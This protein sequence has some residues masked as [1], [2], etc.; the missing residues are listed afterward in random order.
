MQN[1]AKTNPASEGMSEMD[2]AWMVCGAGVGG[3]ELMEA[4]VRREGAARL[5]R[6]E[7]LAE[8]EAAARAEAP[9]AAGVAMLGTDMALEELCGGVASVAALDNV[10]EI[11]AMVRQLDPQAVGRLFFAGA[12]E[13][14][15]ARDQEASGGAGCEAHAE[16][17]ALDSLAAAGATGPGRGDEDAEV[18]PWVS[19][20]AS[21]PPKTA[22][23]RAPVVTAISGRGGVGKTTLLAAIGCCAARMGLRAA[24]L[25]FDLMFGD[26]HALL[27][28]DDPHDLGSIGEGEV[29]AEEDIEQ[30]AMRVG[31]G[32][33]LWGPLR[34]PERAELM[35][36]PCEGLIEVLRGIADIILVDTSVFWGDAAAAAVAG[37]DR[38]LVVGAEGATSAASVMRAIE[39]AARVG[40]P[41]TKMT[42]VL[43]RFGTGTCGEE[44]AMRFEMSV[45][46]RSRVR[47]SHG[48]DVAGASSFG[49][50]DGL[51]AGAGPFALS[52]RR[53]TRALLRELGCPVGSWMEA[54]DAQA[55]MNGRRRPRFRLPWAGA[56]E[57]R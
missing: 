57:G 35:G 50:I 47:I 18:P 13:V 40:V 45:P 23:G 28:V 2:H 8:L 12:T 15:A 52:V 32:L 19:V 1:A 9:H 43:N 22:G 29:R 17:E 42:S 36:T 33:T 25:D 53:V 49:R 20:P 6:V 55:D 26:M 51:M 3:S 39:L 48:G 56:R 44:F 11:L 54:E 4:V 31:P 34:E 21:D 24:V 10:D 46:L 5:R 38:C 30:A 41:R 16:K 14:I 7:S 37:C 27:G